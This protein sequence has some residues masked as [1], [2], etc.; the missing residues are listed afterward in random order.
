MDTAKRKA[1]NKR[2]LSDMLGFI[3]RAGN[4]I[5]HPKI[6]RAHV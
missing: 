1:E 3:E 2:Q 6:G 5:P 4:K